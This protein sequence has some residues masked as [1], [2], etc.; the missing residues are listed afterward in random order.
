MKKIY[1]LVMLALIVASVSGCTS[2]RGGR[3]YKLPYDTIAFEEGVYSNSADVN[4]T[5]PC[6]EY[7][8]RTY[9]YYGNLNGRMKNVVDHCLGYVVDSD[10]PDNR[11]LR[12][13]SLAGTDDYLVRYYVGGIMEQPDCFRAVDTIGMTIDTPSCIQS[14]YDAIWGEDVLSKWERR[15]DVRRAEKYLGMKLD[16]ATSVSGYDDHGG[17]LGDGTLLLR[18]TFSDDGIV[19]KM[20]GKGWRDLPMSNN[21]QI[22]AW[23]SEFYG[24]LLTDLHGWQLIPHI[25]N[26]Y[27][28]FYDRH[29][30]AKD[31][32]DDTNVHSRSSWNLVFA[33]YDSDEHI[34]Y[35]A[36]F[37]T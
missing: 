9:V 36:E 5:Y 12:I 37:D 24:A 10:N 23:G 18:F 8:G 21:C 16:D 14:N 28:Y 32:Y 30:E 4:D 20:T 17:F 25:D 26:G 11:D 19:D 22:I 7:A 13:Y 3:I 15:S 29:S 35:F 31:R 27:Y 33:V 34:L 6:I 2:I 1:L